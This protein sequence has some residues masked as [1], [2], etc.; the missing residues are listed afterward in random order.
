[1]V[2]KEK[3]YQDTDGSIGYYDCYFDSSNI[4]QCT[5][6]PKLEK[7]FVSFHKGGVYSYLNINNKI[8]EEFKNAESQGKYFIDNIKKNTSRFPFIKEFTLY[9]S[10]IGN[11]KEIIEENLIVCSLC[12]KKSKL[13]EAINQW[14][15]IGENNICPDCQGEEIN[16][17][18]DTVL[19]DLV[20]FNK[21]NDQ[22]TIEKIEPNCFIFELKGEE[23]IKIT[24]NGFYW[25]GSLVES[26]NEI[27][28][29]F[30]Q[31]LKKY[32]NEI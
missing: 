2:V 24:S 11:Y 22:T 16:Q 21:N 31:Y 32:N 18:N 13:S 3:K 19:S 27:Y 14:L 1:M 20:L 6:F 25:K 28:S 15:I 5:Y 4:L 30:K 9:P 12:E 29:L 17:N 26:D 23:L 10:E 7:L 8:F